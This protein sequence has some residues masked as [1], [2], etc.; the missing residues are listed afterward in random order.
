MSANFRFNAKN[1]FV[2]YPQANALTSE[3]LLQF[4]TDLGATRYTIAKENHQSGDVHFHCLIEWDSPYCTRNA[5]RFDVDDHHPNIQKCRNI[6]NVWKYITKDGDFTTNRDEPT[7]DNK[8]SKYDSLAN[9]TSTN[10]FWELAKRELP[11]DF[12]INHE[13]LEYYANKRFKIEQPEYVPRYT[14]FNLPEEIKE[15]MNT[16]KPKVCKLI[17]VSAML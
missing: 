8:S 3:R 10:E 11:R 9:A 12:V 13:R 15:W 16:E 14:D 2:T 4:Y 17:S 7:T 5:R 1:L 6:R